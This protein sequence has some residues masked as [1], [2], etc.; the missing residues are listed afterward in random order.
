MSQLAVTRITH[1]CHLIEI[2]GGTV[3]TDP[4]FSEKAAY[5]PGEPI[6]LQV[7]ELPPLDGILISHHHYDHC[8]LDALATYPDKA[9]P[10]LVCL[11]VAKQAKSHG[12][13]NIT[14]LEPWEQA[15]IGPVTVTA[16]PAKHQVQ[17]ITFVLQSGDHT[18]YF[19]GDTMYIPELEELP[20]RF[21]SIDLALVPT[22]GLRIRPLLNKKIVMDANDAA[23][24]IALLRP[25]LAIPHHYAFT[26]GPIGD[27]L[28]TKGERNPQAFVDAAHRLAPGVPVKVISPGQRLVLSPSAGAA[29]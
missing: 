12:F 9:V 26:S 15:T 1:S 24:L 11:P 8:D 28:L 17:E 4:W 2:G 18:V 27:R 3:L 20:T 23:R 13:S 14:I 6:A 22:N 16:A 7:K 21:P 19:A 25:A 5:H 10:L 29:H